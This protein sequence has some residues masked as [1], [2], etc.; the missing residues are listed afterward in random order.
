MPGA[1]SPPRSQPCTRVSLRELAEC[2]EQASS[3]V[4]LDSMVA[5][6][7]AA[8]PGLTPKDLD[9]EK[10][11]LMVCDRVQIC[12]LSFLQE[13]NV[14]MIVNM[15]GHH[16]S[17]FGYPPSFAKKA[18]SFAVNWVNGRYS[19]LL[20]LLPG[21]AETLASSQTIAIHCNHGF[22][23]G[24]LGFA[25]LA[26]MMF[27]I[28]PLASL[29]VLG[30]SRAIWHEYV[31]G[32][33]STNNDGVLWQNVMWLRGLAM[34]EPRP[35]RP[36][37]VFGGPAPAVRPPPASSQAASSSGRAAAPEQVPKLLKAARGKKV[38]KQKYLYRAMTASL[39]EFLAPGFEPNFKGGQL[40][41]AMLDAVARGSSYTSPFLHF[42]L[43]FHEARKWW[44]KGRQLRGETSNLICQVEVAKLHEL[45]SS[46]DPA[47]SQDHVPR[48]IDGLRPGQMLDLSSNE[49]T[50]KFLT[51][52]FITP[53]VED[54][55]SALGHAHQ[56]KEV[57]VAWRGMVDAGLF[58]VVDPNS[59]HLR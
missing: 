55:L 15:C 8:A 9:L 51:N 42:S 50:K 2:G 54:Q 46:S 32:A 17:K 31:D 25:A 5:R 49:S 45:A 26:K 3:Q 6:L 35:S 47:S 39:S 57:L 53:Q 4:V 12:S 21:A 29:S 41:E 34:Y 13:K 38:D 59:G 44:T 18:A 16:S 36:V 52:A 24:P 27:G 40:A 7:L 37:P 33:P 56:V 11:A 22:H 58:E 14:G 43:D 48:L 23:R 30:S 20:S 28:D 1:I 19:Q 10:A